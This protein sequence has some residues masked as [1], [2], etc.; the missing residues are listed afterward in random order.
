LSRKNERNKAEVIGF[1]GVGLDN[2][3]GHQRVTR[4]EHFVLLGGSEETHEQMQEVVIKFTQSLRQRGKK[5]P[6]TEPDEA[7]DLLRE[8]MDS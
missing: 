6:E 3:D 2:R 5:L 1:L 7:L 4:S 8:A